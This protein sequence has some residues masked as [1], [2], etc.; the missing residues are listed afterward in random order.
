LTLPILELSLDYPN[1]RFLYFSLQ[2]LLGQF[3]LHTMDGCKV[4]TELFLF[5]SQ[6]YFLCN[7]EMSLFSQVWQR[8][9][10]QTRLHL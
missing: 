3:E 9:I 1:E 7:P 8:L 10:Y 6:I 2:D 4:T 5:S